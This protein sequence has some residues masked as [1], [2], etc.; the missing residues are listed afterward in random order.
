MNPMANTLLPNSRL[1]LAAQLARYFTAIL[2][3][4]MFIGTHL[5]SHSVPGFSIG[6][7]LIHYSA[8]LA[9]TVSALISWEL[10]AGILRP[11]HFFVVW[12]VGTLYGA[13]DEITQTPFGRSCDG[14]DWLADIA[15]IVSGI[16]I[17]QLL[18]GFFFRWRSPAVS[19]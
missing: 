4:A 13:F 1:R 3:L 7:K 8:Y 17:Y 19:A 12:L 6:D 2:L 5:P 16:V 10:S 15:G 14:L 11:S 9:L 18:R